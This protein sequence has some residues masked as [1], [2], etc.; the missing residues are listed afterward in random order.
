[1][2]ILLFGYPIDLGYLCIKQ[3]P[4]RSCKLLRGRPTSDK[5]DFTKNEYVQVNETCDTP[6]LARMRTPISLSSRFPTFGV[7]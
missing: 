5:V 4:R 2:L 6:D 3:K 7:S 1:M